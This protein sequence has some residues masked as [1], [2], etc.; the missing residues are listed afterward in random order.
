LAL[1]FDIIHV[2]SKKELCRNHIDIVK[3]KAT[4]TLNLVRRNFSKGTTENIRTTIYKTFVRP[5]LEYCSAIW[6]PYTMKDIAALEN[7]QNKAVR[8]IT[9]D[10]SSYSSVTSMKTRLNIPSL[11]ERRFI[12]RQKIFYKTLHNLHAFTFPPYVTPNENTSL[13]HHAA[14][15]HNLAF[16]CA[17]YQNSCLPRTIRCWNLLPEHIVTA[18]SLESLSNR[19]VSEINL[20]NIQVCATNSIHALGARPINSILRLY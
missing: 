14:T 7:I 18:P 2:Y 4:R 11:Q 1:Q 10:F 9:T 3:T 17:Q 12:N 16:S 13:R 15:Y 6:D 19:L 8:F 20:G 5:K